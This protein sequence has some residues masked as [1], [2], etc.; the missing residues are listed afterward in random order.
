MVQVLPY[1]PSFGE[2]L[3]A[4]LSEAGTDIA[5]G[6][7]R[8]SAQTALQKLLN[9]QQQTVSQSGMPVDQANQFGHQEQPQQQIS[10][11]QLPIK[12]VQLYDLA[13]KAYGPEQAN[14]L[15]KGYLESQKLN[16]KEQQNIRAEE[17]ALGRKAHE[18]FFERVSSDRAK[19]PE[20]QLSQDMI[21]DSI[22][23]GDIDPWS[24]AHLADIARG[25]GAPEALLAP[26][27]NP[28]SKEFKTARKTF[29]GNTI[30]D[31]F[32]GTTT[33]IE[34]NLA[35]D[36]LAEIGVSKEGNLASAWGLQAALDIRRER[37]RLADQLAEQGVPPSKIPPTVDKM[38]EPYIRETKSEYFDALK[39]LRKKAKGGK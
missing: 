34:I 37:V 36:M 7:Q 5:K 3:A 22:K 32:R 39:E 30:K 1:V 19:L 28:G 14:I 33:K 31:A 12:A 10:A 15:A 29:I 21:L 20:E 18:G 9:P 24:K 35:E 13:S 8:R 27:E 26:L 38:M 16:I 17:R 23:S 11:D 2:K 25:F 6:I 4:T